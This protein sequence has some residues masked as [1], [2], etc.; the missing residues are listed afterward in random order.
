MT[1]P[2]APHRSLRLADFPTLVAA[3]DFAA[4]GETGLN[5][6]SVRGQLAEALAYRELRA[7]AL[8]L[9][10][11]LLAAGLA[12]GDRIGLIAETD[13]DFVRA[14][15]ACQYAGL[16]RRPYPCPPRSAAARATS[17]RSAACWRPPTP[18]P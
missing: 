14:Y 5:L 13:G 15:F 17:P 2:T 3:L 16:V 4:Q 6:Y 18:R 12:A 8:A 9:A 10:G 1:T 7:Q 11:G